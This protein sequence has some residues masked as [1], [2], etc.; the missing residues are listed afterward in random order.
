MKPSIRRLYLDNGIFEK[1]I[2]HGWHYQWQER[3]LESWTRNL[4]GLKRGN[5]WFSG[6]AKTVL[7]LQHN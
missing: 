3:T 2:T 6:D 7:T 5:A 4:F 1:A